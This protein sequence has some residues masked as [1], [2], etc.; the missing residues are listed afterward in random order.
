MTILMIVLYGQINYMLEPFAHWDLSS[1]RKMALASPEINSDIPIPF[2]YRVLGPYIVGLLPIPDTIGFYIFSI[3]FS[4]CLSFQFYYLLRYI[5]LSTTISTVTVA[6]FLFNKYLFGITIWNYFQINDLLSLNFIIII[7]LSIWRN[8]WIVFGVMLVLGAITKEIS[9]LMIPVAFLY[10]MEKKE[11]STKWKRVVVAII[12]ALVV[13]ILIRVLIPTTGGYSLLE[14]FLIYSQKV[15]SPESIFRK[16]VNS[17]LPFYFIPFIF[18]KHTLQFF[19]TK[20]YM[21]LYI[22]LVFFSTFFGSNNERLIAPTFI[23]FYIL[24]GTILQELNPNKTFL[25]FL[26]VIG[27]LSSFHHVFA[28]YPLPNINWTYFFTFGTTLVVTIC[29]Y[30]LKRRSNM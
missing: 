14:S 17:Y 25:L 6:L 21:L 3:F 27:F 7:L 22:S 4:I 19:R 5:G 1:Y 23:V 13:Y 29:M 15:W 20:K 16:L 18:F 28:K 8:Q 12:P 11:L 24:I 26:M 30:F 9:M 2:A 10:I